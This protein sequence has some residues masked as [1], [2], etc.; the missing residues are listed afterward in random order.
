VVPGSIAA[1]LLVSF[2]FMPSR[3][4]TH[5]NARAAQ[6]VEPLLRE[7]V[8]R[9]VLPNGLV[10]LLR[11]DHAAEVVSVQVWVRSGSIHEAPRLGSGVSH[12]LEHMMFKG[13]SRRAGRD[14]SA[15]VQARGGYIN[16]YTTYDR[17]V[18]YIDVPSEHVETALDVLADAV[19]HSIL[20]AGEVDKE[21]DVILREIAMG[22]D[23][24]DQRVAQA[25]METAFREHPYRFPII[26]HKEVF[27]RLSREDLVA[28][29]GSRYVA[30]N[31]VLVVAGAIDPLAL[32]PLVERHFGGLVRAAVAP[33]VVPDEPGQ[34]AA[35]RID[36]EDDVQVFRAALGYQV[37]GL[38]H[39]DTPALDVLS[40]I[41]GHGDSSIL[42]QALREKKKLVHHVDA[43]NWNPGTKG[44][45]FLTMVGDADKGERALDALAGEV[46]RV[47]ARG[48]TQAQVDKAVR[49]TLVAEVN[50]RRTVSG[51]A[52]RIGAAEVVVGDVDYPATYLARL[53]RLTT[54][55][56]QRVAREYLRP[57]N[58][59]TAT[60][61]PKGAVA[62]AGV[63]RGDAAAL[64]FSEEK[65]P[66]GAR[67]VWRENHRLPQVHL[68]IVWQGGPAFEPADRRGA[69]ALLST[70][71]TLDTK[72][73]SAA[74][75][76]EAIESVGGSF[77]EFS[78]NNSFG[79]A[80]EVLPDD[81]ELALDLLEEAVLRPAFKPSTV[82]RERD[83]QAAEI[84]EE[85]DDIVTATRRRL[86]ALFFGTHPLSTESAGTVESVARLDL[87][88]L[89]ALHRE[90]VVGG[91]T[92]VA[93]SG[94]FR[95]A[96]L[97]PKLKRLLAK[98]PRGARPVVD[99]TFAGA[100]ELGEHIEP[101]DR[102]QVA[103][104]EGY[105]GVGLLTPD[106]YVSEVADELF[107][108]MSSNLFERVREQKSLA[109]FVRSGRVIG[110]H[111]GLFFFMAGT[112]TAG[113][114]E[115]VAEFEAEIARVQGGGVTADEIVRCRTRL[116]AGR[117]M[118]MQSNAACASQAALNAL[119]GLP[120]NDWRNYDGHID[121]VTAADL[122]RFAREHLTPDK[123][124]R[125][126]TG[127]VKP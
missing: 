40:L 88:T 48:V 79:L 60:L 115:V 80:F 36:L 101:S 95:R 33:M 87:A 41:L 25:L 44:L 37:P 75:V 125:L 63:A 69:T 21:R 28:Y 70:L 92:I 124:V 24:P 17:T 112:H 127:A 84:A 107:S 103:V 94:D 65:L 98:L 85:N 45:F 108:G 10:V 99:S 110:L 6:L 42:W 4:K 19:F 7:P 8:L 64:D 120:L 26:G 74:Q 90:L 3:K 14:I 34:L 78:G 76:A 59:T 97:L 113:A 15:E 96:E 30:N 56:L 31:A 13:T 81:V 46:T 77:G 72:K 62:S 106:F 100:A 50:V 121:A 82:A 126:L 111:A 12:Y 61:R 47:C 38:A 23:D 18:Y 22:L 114:R 20:P 9:E 66:G 54:A 27:S 116:K 73:R 119:Y 122:Q 39:P 86:R 71:L 16:A 5:A 105:P 51:Q 89:R 117:R 55:D 29:H 58:L 109:Y 2:L 93:V 32:R 118:S 49:Q 83:A 68:R 57:A 53:A 35:R 52:S 67:I 91:N 102:Q 43:S 11:P 104:F 1:D 123:R